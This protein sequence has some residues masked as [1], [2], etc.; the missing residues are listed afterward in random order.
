MRGAIPPL[1]Q[2]VFMAWCLV[3]HTDNLY[4]Y[5]YTCIRYTVM[6]RFAPLGSRKSGLQQMRVRSA[7]P[8]HPNSD[9]D[10]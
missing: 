8:L 2:Y 3:K 4:I 6:T 7:R 5:M 9:I 1:P 10:I